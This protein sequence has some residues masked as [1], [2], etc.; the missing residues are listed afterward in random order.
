MV[1]VPL[2]YYR[3][4]GV[5]IQATPEQLQQAY[6]DRAQQLPRYHYSQAAIAVRKELLE[7]A[8]T[9][10][11]NLEQRRLYDAE[12]LAKTYSFNSPAQTPDQAGS[13]VPV[14]ESSPKTSGI[15]IPDHQL[16]GALLLLQELGEYELVLQLGTPYLRSGI[17]DLKHHRLGSVLSEA[18]IVLTVA[19]ADLEL[20]REHWQQGQHEKAAQSLQAGLELLLREG[21]FS[22]I[23]SE[24]RTDLYKLRPYRVLELLIS[25]NH[26]AER[27][28]GLSLLKEMLVDRGGIDGTGS[29]HSGLSI[30]EFLQFIQQLRSY[31]SVT[32]QQ[33]LFE[34]EAGRPSAVATYLAVYALVA[35]GYVQKQ[36]ALIL[37]AKAMLTRLSAHQE[38]YLEQAVCALL[39]GQTEAANQALE[40]SHEY[41][42]L[43]FI[44][45]Y[46]ADSPDLIPGL[47]L[48]TERWLQEEVFPHFRDLANQKVNLKGYFADE[49]VQAYLEQLLVEIT[50]VIDARQAKVG[51]AAAH[52]SR[53][54]FPPASAV[55]TSRIGA[56]QGTVLG[57]LDSEG[58]THPRRQ[59]LTASSQ[60]HPSTQKQLTA[61]TLPASSTVSSAHSGSS[62]QG[63]AMPNPR[64]GK[65]A[66]RPRIRKPARR[67]RPLMFGRQRGQFQIG[68][69]LF[70]LLL[71]GTAAAA[72]VY[73]LRELRSPG[74][75]EPRV[76]PPRVQQSPL[77]VPSPSTPSQTQPTA[78]NS[79]LNQEGVRQ[80]VRS[81]QLT[82]AAALGRQ[83]TTQQLAQVLTGPALAT[84]QNRAQEA[85][86]SNSYWEYK[87]N[88][89]NI[90]AV[91]AVNPNQVRAEVTLN[92]T[93]N[94]F[95]QGQPRSEP[96]YT[97]TYRVRYSLV[98][99][100]GKWLIQDMEVL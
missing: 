97:D 19:L 7:T 68:L 11:S 22:D 78:G 89:L 14:P 27:S 87:L 48:Y 6:E 57:T 44:R 31:L 96:S 8:Y 55:Q 49:Q 99:R 13:E 51:V 58:Q 91:Q 66:N 40:L 72:I 3:I 56:A 86:A 21:L 63:W 62:S 46:S 93:A 54:V 10:L 15:E 30:N 23:Q 75:S 5:P 41:E 82:K 60:V 80:L 18:D 12:F 42:S 74:P 52:L 95:E 16:T 76:E 4:L 45:E 84:W 77:P 64:K 43:A 88:R 90:N 47:Y 65:V 25:E 79:T 100:D 70:S 2:D 81:W 28:H 17:L 38:V 69:I 9:V 26:S 61:A 39:L 83:R 35:Q 34:Q 37:R 85:K 29:D 67:T 71:V 32:E 20:G 94:F 36:P 98:R 73:A 24:I 59:V 1:Q 50:P 92:E 33:E 53:A